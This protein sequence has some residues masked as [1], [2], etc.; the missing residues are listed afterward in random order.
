MR[1]RLDRL[2]EAMR[3]PRAYI[4]E[5]ALAAYLDVNEWQVEGIKAA[6]AEADSPATTWVSH[7]ELTRRWKAKV[8]D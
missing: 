4:V 6:V 7:D 8:A 1:E 2:S 3:R 5:A